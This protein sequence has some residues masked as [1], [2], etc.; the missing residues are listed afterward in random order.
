MILVSLIVRY[1]T[2]AFWLATNQYHWKI[3][4]Q[5]ELNFVPIV[6][7]V[8]LCPFAIAINFLLHKTPLLRQQSICDSNQF[9]L[10]N[11]SGSPLVVSYSLVAQF[12]ASVALDFS[13]MS[14]R[15][16]TFCLYISNFKNSTSCFPLWVSKLVMTLHIAYCGKKYLKWLPKLFL[17]NSLN[18]HR[19]SAIMCSLPWFFCSKAKEYL[20]IIW[21]SSP[22]SKN[23]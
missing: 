10:S 8:F 23:F 15:M 14:F 1:N 3:F 11:M 17:S 22:S 12:T 4:D 21:T 13:N 18:V 16:L 9:C 20:S 5:C 19:N 6:V 2:S 7:V